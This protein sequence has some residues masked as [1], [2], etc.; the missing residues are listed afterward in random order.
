MSC[1]AGNGSRILVTSRDQHLLQ[2]P[3]MAQMQAEALGQAPARLLFFWH[4]FLPSASS[5]QTSSRPEISKELAEE[6]VRLCGGLPLS[7][8][9][10]GARLRGRSSRVWA[11]AAKILPNCEGILDRLQISYN[12]LNDQQ[13]EMFLDVACFCLG[14]SAALAEQLWEG[15]GFAAA[16]GLQTLQDRCLVVWIG[17]AS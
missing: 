4:A 15:N 12:S 9:V 10:L 16:D 11:E 7:L 1:H 2:L 13:R 14:R 8:K 5:C 17:M 3:G 6:V